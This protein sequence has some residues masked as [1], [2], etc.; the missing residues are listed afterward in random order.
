MS[1]IEEATTTINLAALVPLIQQNCLQQRPIPV[2][3][4]VEYVAHNAGRLFGLEQPLRARFAR[5]QGGFL[6]FVKRRG[7]PQLFTAHRLLPL[8]DQLKG[9]PLP[10]AYSVHPRIDGLID[11]SRPQRQSQLLGP[12]LLIDQAK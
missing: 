3:Q 9:A 4:L 2:C 10:T 7:R 11:E 12:T 5:R 1:H 8:F 6:L